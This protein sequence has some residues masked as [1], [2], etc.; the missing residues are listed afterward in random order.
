MG[1]ETCGEPAE[2]VVGTQ[3]VQAPVIVGIDGSEVAVRAAY[4]AAMEADA[5]QVPLQLVHIATHDEVSLE[6]LEL[7]LTAR[8]AVIDRWGRTC[9]RPAPAIEPLVLAGDPAARLAELS[10]AS[11]LLVL[12]DNQ[13]GPLAGLLCGSVAATLA[14]AARCPV[15]L[16]RPLHNAASAVGPVLVAVDGTESQALPAAFSAAATRHSSLL[17]ADIRRRAAAD[18]DLED[19]IGRYQRQF[20][21]VTVQSVTV[22]GDRQTALE[23]FSVTAQ[24]LV[25]ARDGHR[26]LRGPLN[27]TLH[28]ALH[29]THCPVLVL[30]EGNPA[31]T[32]SD[33]V[34]NHRTSALPAFG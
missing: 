22:A 5:R 27:P 25:I 21:T 8:R 9:E 11:T 30:P 16:T 6:G 26:R 14:G 1:S 20:P 15:A 13:A 29:H 10:A 17:V 7:V 34:D 12:G 24:L 19:L 23:R 33:H 32:G 4:W 3:E 2:S 18:G 31:A 28:L